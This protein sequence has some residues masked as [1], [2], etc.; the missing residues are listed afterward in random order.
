MT[1][2]TTAIVL[3]NFNGA[4]ELRASL[5]AILGQTRPA[6]QILVIDDGS[7]D[8]S[9][10]IIDAAVASDP[11]VSVV[12]NDRNLGLPAS[13]ARALAMVVTDY[14]VWT[15]VH[16]R[17]LPTLLETSLSALERHP[18][19]GLCFAHVSPGPRGADPEYLP[20]P[21]AAVPRTPGDCLPVSGGS[22]V[23]RRSALLAVGGYPP[24]LDAH[25]DAFAYLVVA[26]R[27][28]ACVAPERL[29]LPPADTGPEGSRGTAAMLD[30]LAQ[31]AFRDVRTAFRRCLEYFLP[32][33]TPTLRVEL[34]R[35]RLWDLWLAYALWESREW[36]RSRGLTG[37]RAAVMVAVRMVRG[38]RTWLR[39]R[40]VALARA[41]RE[42][43]RT[44]RAA[45][46]GAQLMS[47]ALAQRLGWLDARTGARLVRVR[48]P[49]TQ[50]VVRNMV[51]WQL[52]MPPSGGA[53][54][55][56]GRLCVAEDPESVQLDR[57]LSL[58]CL[59]GNLQN[60]DILFEE[61]CPATPA[62]G[63]DL[64]ARRSLAL[65][66]A[67]IARLPR[68][69]LPH[70]DGRRTAT[71]YLK[72]AHPRAFV[73]ALSL[74]EDD[75]GFV[76]EELGKWLP[77]LHRLRREAPG[78]AFCLLNR[79][80]LGRDDDQSPPADISPVRSLG[81]SLADAVALAQAADAFIGRLDVFGLAAT[82]AGR[83]GVY[84]DEANVARADAERAVWFVSEASPEASLDMLRVVLGRRRPPV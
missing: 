75:D 6:D 81:F 5:D 14:L 68:A 19:A 25:A 80:M 17:L 11:R 67:E 12:R 51:A 33:R 52:D 50:D 16:E 26:V 38:V 30:L 44:A 31:P 41:G 43:F 3:Y 55:V 21:A 56:H 77:H 73:V 46:A 35:R 40:L 72:I 49:V 9:P 18:E 4:R 74:S 64:G 53:A 78:V 45:G 2:A 13:R 36:K 60:F 69:F 63:V 82:A 28:G 23:V 58:V 76:G 32:W 39:G 71:Q 22:V 59:S 34:R 62:S 57:L 42:G 7:I 29:A 20:P 70:F 48:G 37:G 27:F 1:G 66:P 83:P 10:A 84:I 61:P 15:T 8:D 24:D 47:Y 65:A 79:T 54:A